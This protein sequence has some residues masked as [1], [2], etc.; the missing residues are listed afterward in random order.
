ML[1]QKKKTLL[2]KL[3]ETSPDDP[4]GKINKVLAIYKSTNV[5]GYCEELKLVYKDL[6]LSHLVAANL[7]EESKRK[8]A[9]FADYLLSRES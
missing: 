8:F 3:Y 1:R 7:S 6:A 2:D 4:A 9:D 5:Q